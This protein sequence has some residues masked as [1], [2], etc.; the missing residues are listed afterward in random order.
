LRERNGK[1]VSDTLS[2]LWSTI[3]QRKQQR[4]TGSYTVQLLE[5]GENEILKKVGEEAV[6][7]IIAAKGEGDE[8]V[9]YELA[10]LIYHSMVLLAARDLTWSDVEAEMAR[11]FG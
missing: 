7:V 5:A 11:R 2:Q 10:D 9:L 3:E 8:R 6:E 1:V 4:P